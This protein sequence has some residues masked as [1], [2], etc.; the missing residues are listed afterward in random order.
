MKIVVKKD[1]LEAAKYAARLLADELKANPETVFGLATGRTME[2]LYAELCEIYKAEKLDFSKAVSFN[3]DEYAGLPGS[4]VNSYRAY[5]QM[6]LFD[7]VNF[8]STNLP[9]G[10][11]P[12]AEAEAVRYDNAIKAAGLDIQLLGIGNNGHIGFNEPG[13]A[14]DSR[15]RHVKLTDA[16]IEQNQG[17]FPKP[18]DM[19]R[20]AFTMGIGTI[21]EAKKIILVATGAAKTGILA[22]AVAGKV[23][24][25]VPASVLQNHSNV[26]IVADEDAA[27]EV[28]AELIA[29]E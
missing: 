29:A 1:K 20:Y 28:P 10:V 22:A 18:E 12:D 25:D 9:D 8:K 14:F 13:T 19:P 4:D 11:A 15:T 17:L 23:T 3:L 6:N 27:A 2:P 21:M 16:T 7:H 5:M 24:E 26:I